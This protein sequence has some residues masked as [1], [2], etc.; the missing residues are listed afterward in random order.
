MQNLKC[1]QCGS[2]KLETGKISS[3]IAQPTFQPDKYKLL[4]V[5]VDI[6][7]KPFMC[8]DCGVVVMVGDVKK[9]RK[10]SKSKTA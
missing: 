5:N 7:L 10:I 3:A 1:S 2:S 9:L 4:A 8:L 6:T